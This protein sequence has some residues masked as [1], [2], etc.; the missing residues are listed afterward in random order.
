[1]GISTLGA[2]FHNAGQL[3]VL[4]L[5]FLRGAEALRLLPW[6]TL[7]ATLLGAFTGIAARALAAYLATRHEWAGS[8]HAETES[9]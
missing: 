3:A 8:L 2:V 4:S 7:S 6:L 9:S 1:V 5:L